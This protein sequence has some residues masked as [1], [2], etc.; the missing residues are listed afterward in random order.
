MV[1]GKSSIFYHFDHK[2]AA[3]TKT[4]AILKNVFAVCP[5]HR[6]SN[7]A[8]DFHGAALRTPGENRIIL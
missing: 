1:Q 5:S 8:H 3:F 2:A 6:F 4:V 7:Y